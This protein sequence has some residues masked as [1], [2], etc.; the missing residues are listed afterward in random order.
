M[1]KPVKNPPGIITGLVII[2]I[3]CGWVFL[4]K[5]KPAAGCG[6]V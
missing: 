4:K 5:L 6:C 2:K 3:R 1:W